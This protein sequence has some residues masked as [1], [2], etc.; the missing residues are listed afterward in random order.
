MNTASRRASYRDY[1][2]G[3]MRDR[4][5]KQFEFARSVGRSPAW[6][7]QILNGRR[8]LQ[9]ALAE[10]IA[11]RLELTDRQRV[12]FLT[13][14]E[15]E[16]GNSSLIRDRAKDLLS[17]LEKPEPVENTAD[18]LQNRL[19]DWHLGAILELARC[20]EY[21]PEVGWV[22]AT[23]RP[24]LT[25][26]QAQAAMDELV[27]H[28]L[29][30]EHYR[31]VEGAPDLGTARQVD[32][33]HDSNRA[34]EYHRETLAMAQRALETVP[35][36]DRLYVAGSL[37]LSEDDY[38]KL[39]SR[40]QEILAPTLYSAAKEVPNRVFHLNLA[41]FPISLYSDNAVDP[42]TIEDEAP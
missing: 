30:D 38:L 29:L 14:V 34:A 26:A 8:N 2:Q 5:L 25:D 4:D 17:G 24:R 32:A 12:E 39:M 41:L 11:T 37:A 36:T 28:G 6:L 9:P 13:L 16:V 18:A 23:L 15:R 35:P 33:G 27:A 22:A 3:L 19:C 40:L 21:V 1:L 10:Q 20:E 7:S 31:L 42:R